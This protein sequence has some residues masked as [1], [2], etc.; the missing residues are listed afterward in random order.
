[1]ATDG[2]QLPSQVKTEAIAS[3]SK[4]N[5]ASGVPSK[6][7]KLRKRTKTGCLTCRKRRIKCGE[8]RPTCGN[9]IKS[10]RHCEGYNQ[11]VIFKPPIGD[12]PNAQQAGASTIPFHTAQMPS[13]QSAFHHSQQVGQLQNT[14]FTPL[15]PRVDYGPL[16]G[17]GR[18]LATDF[19]GASSFDVNNWPYG[20]GTGIHP[21][22]A[23]RF[24]ETPFSDGIA[25]SAAQYGRAAYQT[26]SVPLGIVSPTEQHHP[27]QK[28]SYSAGVPVP[29]YAQGPILS[30]HGNS[31]LQQ[32]L[33]YAPHA[34][35]PQPYVQMYQ[36]PKLDESRNPT[37]FGDVPS[38][39]SVSLVEFGLERPREDLAER[40]YGA[41]PPPVVQQDEDAYKLQQRQAINFFLNSNHAYESTTRGKSS[42]SG[43]CQ[44]RYTGRFSTLLPQGGV[45]S[46]VSCSTLKIRLTLVVIVQNSPSQG[47][48]LPTNRLAID[49]CPTT[50][51]LFVQTQ[52]NCSRQLPSRTK[53]TITTMYSLTKRWKTSMS[54]I[55]WSQVMDINPI[56]A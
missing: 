23:G 37:I 16:T 34:Q 5:G 12:W 46:S 42:Q 36:F 33:H 10:K 29:S 15:R 48:N 54:E 11:R 13:A 17:N 7:P 8:E 45:E 27:Q 35:H 56:S 20:N 53:T 41:V 47:C 21:S 2:P 1:M 18:G 22:Q 25:A 32:A 6:A 30:E 38:Q 24:P 28:S 9:C 43:T 51:Q 19:R 49:S 40:Q 4:S 3:A 26:P 44:P 50:L 39:A 14:S 55:T 52:H 31:G